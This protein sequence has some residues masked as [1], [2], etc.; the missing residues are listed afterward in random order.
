M[1]VITPST[2]EAM[3]MQVKAPEEMLTTNPNPGVTH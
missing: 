2:V 1:S 3:L